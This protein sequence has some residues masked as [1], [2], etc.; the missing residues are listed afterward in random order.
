VRRFQSIHPLRTEVTLLLLVILHEPNWNA[1]Q[2]LNKTIWPLIKKNKYLK[3]C[4]TVPIL[5]KSAAAEQHKRRILNLGRAEDA[6]EVKKQARVVL[7][8]LRFGAGIKKIARSHAMRY[9]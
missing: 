7:A 5:P 8:P 9:T 6:L 4:K 1:V 2:Y 3:V